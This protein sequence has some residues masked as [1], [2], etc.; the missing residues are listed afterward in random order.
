MIAIAR[1]IPVLVVAALLAACDA[2]VSPIAPAAKAQPAALASNGAEVSFLTAT[3]DLSNTTIDISC[4]DGRTDRVALRG[5]LED[6]TSM[7]KD[8]TG[9]VHVVYTVK[10]VDMGG[11]SEVTGEEYRAKEQHQ[12]VGTDRLNGYAGGFRRRF[13]LVGTES[14]LRYYVEAS[15]RYVINPNGELVVYRQELERGCE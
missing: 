13:T 6:R 9:S 12:G 4:A 1:C 15:A 7:V 14:G 2:S 11:T 8:P 5:R 3:Y 10:S